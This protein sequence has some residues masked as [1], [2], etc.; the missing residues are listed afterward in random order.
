M[1]VVDGK[2]VRDRWKAFPMNNEMIF[3]RLQSDYDYCVAHGY[4]VVGVFL[5]G[6]QNYKVDT[7]TS[8]IDVKALVIPSLDDIIF[9]KIQISEKVKRDNGELVIYDIVNMHQS[10]IKQAINF[11]EILFTEYKIMNPEYEHLYAPMFENNERIAA[12]NK[13][14]VLRCSL[15]MAQNKNKQLL[16]TVP[17]NEQRMELLGWD[18]KALAEILRLYDFFATR[19]YDRKSY[20]DSLVSKNSEKLVL[21]KQGITNFTEDTALEMA[22]KVI[23]RMSHLTDKYTDEH[24]EVIDEEAVEIINEVTKNVVLKYIKTEVD[25]YD[26]AGS[27]Y[28]PAWCR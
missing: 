23:A 12:L 17:S 1:Q 3:E 5:F 18:Y 7:P 9:G 13:F 8:D 11:V 14:K 19:Y 2:H 16:H 27:T 22:T 28:W 15:S 10:I 26:G 20:K 24:G 25:K 6:S 4:E 21:M